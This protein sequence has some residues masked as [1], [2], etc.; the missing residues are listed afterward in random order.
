MVPNTSCTE[1]TVLDLVPFG[2]AD[3]VHRYFALRLSPPDWQDWKP[4]QFLMIRPDSFGLE[5]PWGRP[6]GICLIRPQHLICFFQVKGRGTE[7]M[8]Q[9]RPHDK[10]RVWGP[11]G[12]GF[13]MEPDTPTL[14]LAGGMGIVPFIGYVVEHP[15]AW[16]VSMLF[17]HRDPLECYPVDSINEHIPVDT[18]RE[19]VPGDLD[20][21]IFTLQERIKEYAAQKGLILA[22]GPTP[23]LKT[24]QGFAKEYGARLQISLENKMACGVGGCLGC[25]VRTTDAWPD[26]THRNAPVQCCTQGPVFWA[27]QVVLS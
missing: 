18:L 17:G 14:L 16:N 10:V 7:R 11:L 15:K 3:P 21:F 1:L 12:N 13:V 27:D 6:L 8:T 23:F 9:L 19:S 26:P 20:N 4:G 22:C 24:V 2:L 25:V 5:L